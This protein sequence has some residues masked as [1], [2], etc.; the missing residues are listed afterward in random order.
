MIDKS[1]SVL[2]ITD[3]K[4]STS[5]FFKAKALKQYS[6]SKEEIYF[7]VSNIG[8]NNVHYSFICN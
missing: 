6:L 7:D 4:R 8:Q 1:I 3:S 5:N 2:D